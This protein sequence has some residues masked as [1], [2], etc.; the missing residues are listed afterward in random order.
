M[1]CDSGRRRFPE[2]SQNTQSC[3]NSPVLSVRRGPPRVPQYRH[4]AYGNSHTCAR[5]ATAAAGT[6]NYTC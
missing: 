6:A 2:P 3:Q 1:R 4:F 5:Y